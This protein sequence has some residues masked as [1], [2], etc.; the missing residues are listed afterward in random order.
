MSERNEWL[1]VVLAEAQRKLKP[2]RKSRPQRAAV[3]RSDKAPVKT[4]NQ[5]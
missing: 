1:E 3:K 5:D 4:R 2:V